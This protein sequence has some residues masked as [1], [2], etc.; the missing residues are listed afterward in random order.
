MDPATA[1]GL[2]SSIISFVTFACQVGER[3]RQFSSLA[4]ELPPDLQVCGDLV[5]VVLRCSERHKARILN[6]HRYGPHTESE[7][8]LAAMFEQS[9]KTVQELLAIIDDISCSGS[10]RNA[11]RAV[12]R[13]GK[14]Q[15]L[16]RE[17][18]QQIL[19]IIYVCQESSSGVSEEVQ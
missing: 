10:F 14:L 2:A 13:Q 8:D 7:S 16:R 9:T 3:A 15:K 17:L 11:L 18:E 19:G 4:G 6:S 12:R 1:A 5:A